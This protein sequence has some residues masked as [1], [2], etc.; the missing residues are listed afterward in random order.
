M[1]R[2]HFRGDTL[3]PVTHVNWGDAVLFCNW[4]SLQ[5][6]RDPCYRKEEMDEIDDV[7]DQVVKYDTWA[8][9]LG[10][11]GYRLPTEDEW[12]YAC[13]AKSTT[14]FSFGDDNEL[15]DQYGV[16]SGN[17]RGRQPQ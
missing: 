6:G 14:A 16:Y 11:N 3:R 8:L 10:A 5:E 15:L 9:V 2:Q 13:R 4:L 1:I 12:E 17:A 7:G